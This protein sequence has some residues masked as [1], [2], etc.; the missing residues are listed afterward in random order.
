MTE[1]V[2][3]MVSSKRTCGGRKAPIIVVLALCGAMLVGWAIMEWR[4]MSRPPDR[5]DLMATVKPDT[6]FWLEKRIPGTHIMER[7][8]FPRDQA[9]AVLRAMA[10]AQPWEP[11]G[12]WNFSCRRGNVDPP[13]EKLHLFWGKDIK[14]IANLPKNYLSILSGNKL[15]FYQD[16]TYVVPAEGCEILDRMFPPE[17]EKEKKGGDRAQNDAMPKTDQ[18][19]K[20]PLPPANGG[21]VKN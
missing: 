1:I 7:S 13:R 12:K 9:I 10:T 20:S 14:D 6:A 17:E 18:T 8:P 15:F 5:L 21:P 19:N 3:T 2:Y 4:P 11:N 16:S